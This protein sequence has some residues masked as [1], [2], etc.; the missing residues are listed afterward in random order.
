MRSEDS[1][2]EG[3]NTISI[4]AKGKSSSPTNAKGVAL[5]VGFKLERTAENSTLRPLN[6]STLLILV[7]IV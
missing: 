5:N 1:L 6:M 4:N 3:S 7:F 2:V